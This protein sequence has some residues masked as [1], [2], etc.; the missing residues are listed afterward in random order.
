MNQPTPITDNAPALG[1][2]PNIS[3]NSANPSYAAWLVCDNAASKIT[4]TAKKGK[5]LLMRF[6]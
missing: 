1:K 4:S 3:V 2:N 6:L 5:V